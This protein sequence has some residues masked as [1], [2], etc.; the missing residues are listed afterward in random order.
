MWPSRLIRE[1]RPS[2][3]D[4]FGRGR[5]LLVTTSVDE[6]WGTWPLWPSFLPL[7]HEIVQFA[8]SGRWGERQRLVG[9][10]LTE[11]F[12]A[13]AVD[14]DVAVSSAG[15]RNARRPRRRKDSFNQL[16]YDKTNEQRHLRSQFRRARGPQRIV[17]RQRRPP[18]EQSCQVRS[19]G[20]CRGAVARPGVHVLDELAGRRIGP[21]GIPGRP[22]MAA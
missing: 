1:T 18:R 3:S 10:P 12:P 15:R 20:N 6:R 7:V 5:S 4:T 16:V 21:G 13:T 17:R 19:G 8:V 14:V 22:N 11:I 9:E 2:L